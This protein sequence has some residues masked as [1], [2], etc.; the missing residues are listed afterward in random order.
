MDNGS[1]PSSPVNIDID[2]YEGTINCPRNRPLVGL[3]KR[4]AFAMAAM[5]NVI[6]TRAFTYILE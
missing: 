1:L 5:Q 4:E 6:T 3:T 2:E